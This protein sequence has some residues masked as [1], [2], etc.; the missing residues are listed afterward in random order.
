MLNPK[1]DAIA[2]MKLFEGILERLQDNE[3]EALLHGEGTL[4]FHSLKKM[5]DS[6]VSKEIKRNKPKSQNCDI[7]RLASKILDIQSREEAYQV[8]SSNLKKAALIEIA[9][10]LDVHIKKNENKEAIIHKIIE[11]VVGA[12]L[13]SKAIK[14]TE[15]RKRPQ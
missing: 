9:S 5:D 4:I 10:T 3:Y 7:N 11:A 6:V 8:L 13:R 15:L 1:Q 2:L 14:E 12:R